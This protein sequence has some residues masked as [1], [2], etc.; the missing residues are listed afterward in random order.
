M[1]CKLMTQIRNPHHLI[2][3]NIYHY[4]VEGFWVSDEE[5]RQRISEC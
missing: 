2:V 4:M 5:L 1:Y 3:L